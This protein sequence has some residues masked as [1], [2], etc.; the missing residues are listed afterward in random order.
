MSSL[1]SI[2]IPGLSPA[3]A[4]PAPRRQWLYFCLFALYVIWGS[5]YLGMRFALM[6][7]FPPLMLG[8]S[9]FLLA[10]TCLYVLLRLKGAP[11]PGRRQWA[12]SAFTGLLLL[13]IGNGGIAIAQQWVPSGVAALVAGS[14]PLWAALFGGLTAGQ[15]PGTSE[16]WGLALGFLGIAV[17][18]QGGAMGSHWLPMVGLVLAPISWAFG[19]M[20]SKRHP[21]MAPGLM[22]TATQMLCAGVMLLG[23]SRLWGE[24]MEALPTPRALLAFFYLVGFGSLVAFSAYGY[25]LTHARPALATSYA[26]VN[27]LVAVLLGWLL[28]GE[29][30]GPATLGAMAAILVA[31][32]LITR[33]APAAPPAPPSRDPTAPGGL[34]R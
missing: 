14:M 8:G 1:P 33:K 27:P 21:H 4:A 19:S 26:Y 34:A 12:A 31:V 3:S 2:A 18:N 28:A 30:P 16:R 22:A 24:R 6:G 32:M 20:W 13:V 11:A 9:R 5:T 10:G 17:L 7:G 29:T 23:V 25:L 15:W